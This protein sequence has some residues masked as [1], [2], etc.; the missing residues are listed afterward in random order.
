MTV[1][2][3]D[4]SKSCTGYALFRDGVDRPILGHW[5]LGSEYTKNGQVFNKLLTCLKEL[6]Q[7]EKFDHIFYEE[8]LN[9]ANLQGFTNIKT[10]NVLAGL[11][12]TIELFGYAKKLQTCRGVN[13][14][15]WRPDFIGRIAQTDA[16]AKARR[17]RSAGDQRASARSDLKLLTMER[18]RQLG[19]NPAVDDEADALGILTYGMQ[20]QG[21]TPPWIANEVLRPPLGCVA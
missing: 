16:K 15:S 12:A 7:V 21:L 13:V 3:V 19:F 5:K 18:S 17:R 10:I 6:R 8:K 14:E 9:P 1:L 11:Q 2:A 20:L 4:Q